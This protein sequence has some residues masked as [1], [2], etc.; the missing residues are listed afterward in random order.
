M[1]NSLITKWICRS[2]WDENKAG[3]VVGGGDGEMDAVQVCLYLDQHP[4]AL[5]R[6]AGFSQRLTCTC[7]VGMHP[8]QQLLLRWKFLLTLSERSELYI[9]F[10]TEFMVVVYWSAFYEKVFL[11]LWSSHVC[12]CVDK[13]SEIPLYTE[14]NSSTP[15]QPTNDNK[16]TVK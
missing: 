1:S 7:A 13:I 2:I 12:K 6:H 11:I 9:M 14:Q 5:P 8:I 10:I 4:T 3:F 16:H 15:L